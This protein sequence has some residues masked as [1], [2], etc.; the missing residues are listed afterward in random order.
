MNPD[1]MTPY[2]LALLAHFQGQTAAELTIRRDDGVEA[3]LA[4]KHYFRAEA[5]F[6]R[7]E[8]EALRH[9]RGNVLDIGAGTGSH[10][11]ALQSESLP[12]TAIDISPH[13]AA[14]MAERGVRSAHQ[15]DVFTY[16]GGPFDTLLLLGH[17]IGMVEDLAGLDRFLI[18]ARTLARNDGQLLL[19]SLDVGRSLDPMNLAY[20]EA[21]RRAGR[22]IGEIRMQIEFLGKP[23]PFCGWLQ[24]DSRTLAEHADRAGW[25]CETILEAENGEYLARLVQHQAV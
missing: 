21:N 1:A 6:T 12:V 2:G 8:F 10:S 19:D 20:H 23:G 13:A 16:R 18:H 3:P 25:R 17:G 15:A 14:I 11:L 4:V 7:I 9:S 22:Y 5:E 24:V